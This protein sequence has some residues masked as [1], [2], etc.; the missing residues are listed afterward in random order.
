MNVIVV[1][2][3][4]QLSSALNVIRDFKGNSTVL[5]RSKDAVRNADN[6]LRGWENIKLHKCESLA[7]YLYAV[8][9]LYFFS[10]C[11]A[12]VIVIGD[13]R[14]FLNSIALYLKSR[15]YFYVSDGVGDDISD[16]RNYVGHNSL[17]R[18]VKSI[19]FNLIPSRKIEFGEAE[20]NTFSTKVDITRAY[21]IGQCL[22]EKG[23]LTFE[24]EVNL[25]KTE[26]CS[27]SNYEWSYI[28]HPKDSELKLN[29]IGEISSKIKVVRPDI[30]IE[31]LLESLDQIPGYCLTFYSTAIIGVSSASNK[32]KCEY[33]RSILP[34]LTSNKADEVKRVYELFENQRIAYKVQE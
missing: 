24:E 1:S 28:A 32:I 5:W 16:G 6:L 19:F 15:R 3:I 25:I 13:N 34:F 26:I 7:A 33:T 18:I 9:K 20:G 2:S 10:S 11:K 8:T 23:T 4:H 14:S 12:E 31:N 21:F 22:S 17:V 29:T 30:S 27:T